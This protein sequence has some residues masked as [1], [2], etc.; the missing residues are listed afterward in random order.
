MIN[1]S[2][3]TLER[4][5]KRVAAF[6]EVLCLLGLG[7]MAEVNRMDEYSDIDFFLIVETGWKK[8]FFESLDWLEVEKIVYSFAN[9][10]DGYK[11]LF[12]NGVY[13]EFAIFEPAELEQ[14][15]FSQGR[16]VYRRSD[17]EAKLVTPKRPPAPWKPA[18]NHVVN[19]ALTNLFVGL[20]REKR[21]EHVSAFR[22]IQVY[23]ATSILHTFPALFPEQPVDVDPYGIDRRIEFR[24]PQAKELLKGFCQGIEKNVASAKAALQFLQSHFEINKA[25]VQAVTDLY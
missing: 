17:F 12:D 2:Y 11:I 13:A 9:T 8:R 10:P 22:F 15:G 5:G 21:G 20:Q 1:R 3:E 4:L 6:P 18:L 24:F 14:A 23:A 16:I 7:S 19:E 25:M